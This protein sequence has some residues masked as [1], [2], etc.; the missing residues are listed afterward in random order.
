MTVPRRGEIHLVEFDLS[1]GHEIQKTRPAL[2]IQNDIGNRHSP[3][4]K[5]AAITSAI[6][7][8]PVAVS[9]APT[10]ANGLSVPS[11]IHLGQ[12]RSVDRERL[13]KRLGVV[14]PTTMR[15]VDD[16]LKISLGLVEI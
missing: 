5:V 14:D 16:A 10:Q 2:I 12:I 3:V 11:K 8:H 7:A 1:R 4:T 15:R 9:I 6:S 13:V